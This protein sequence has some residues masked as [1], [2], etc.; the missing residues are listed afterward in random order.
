LKT[1]PKPADALSMLA[2]KLWLTPGRLT[3]TFD[4]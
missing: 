3:L 1:H 4:G 2:D